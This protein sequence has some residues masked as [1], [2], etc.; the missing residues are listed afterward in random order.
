M[1]TG[2]TKDMDEFTASFSFAMKEVSNNTFF[3]IRDFFKV[4]NN[5]LSVLSH[6]VRT[7]DTLF[8]QTRQYY[9]YSATGQQ[10]YPIMNSNNG[11]V[12]QTIFVTIRLNYGNVVFDMVNVTPNTDYTFNYIKTRKTWSFDL[13]NS[14]NVNVSDILIKLYNES[15]YQ[16]IRID[17][18]DFKDRFV[19]D[20]ILYD[21]QTEQR[22]AGSGNLI[23]LY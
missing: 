2:L 3:Q 16:T 17:S 21:F 5:K 15:E 12:E 1:S 9:A 8:Q 18:L 20:F 19:E 13:K 11:V 7:F 22:K 14:N 10:L 4:N 6:N 23:S